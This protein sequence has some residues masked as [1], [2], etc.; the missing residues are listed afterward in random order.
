MGKENTYDPNQLSRLERNILEALYRTGEASAAEVA[1]ALPG[2]ASEDSVRVTLGRLER[3]GV[4][5]FRRDGQR[6]IYRPAVPRE[7]A[8]SSALRHLVRTYFAGASAS[9]VLRL[10]DLSRSDL[11]EGELAEIAERIEA[12]RE[13]DR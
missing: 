13:E 4:V 1:A 5:D 6:H 7:D 10:I 12:E 2:E 11:S 8:G 9:A 3:R